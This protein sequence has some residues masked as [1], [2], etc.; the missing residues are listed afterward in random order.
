MTLQAAIGDLARCVRDGLAPD[1]PGGS[2]ITEAEK[3]LIFEAL[4][5]IEHHTESLKLIISR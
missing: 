5:A 3:H 4:E 1:G 2:D